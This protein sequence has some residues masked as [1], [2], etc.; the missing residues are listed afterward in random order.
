[1]AP[2]RMKT[3]IMCL[4]TATVASKWVKKSRMIPLQDDQMTSLLQ[5]QHM[6]RQVKWKVEDPFSLLW[7]NGA[8]HV[9]QDEIQKKLLKVLALK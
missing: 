5:R 9:N 6:H 7:L 2:I 1:M 4:E 8:N 3:P